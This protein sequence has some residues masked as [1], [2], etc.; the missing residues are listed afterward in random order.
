MQQIAYWSKPD[1]HTSRVYAHLSSLVDDCLVKRHDALQPHIFSLTRDAYRIIKKQP[2]LG[3]RQESWSVLTH[4]C[5]AN[6][7]EILLQKHYPGF[8][9]LPKKE[10]YAMGL[11]PA[12]AEHCGRN[13]D[14]LIYTIIDDYHMQSS[15]LARVQGRAHRPKT[16]FFDLSKTI[17]TWAQIASTFVCAATDSTQYQAHKQFIKTNRLNFSLL[18]LESIW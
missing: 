5:H 12:I 3:S 16:A 7:A 15:R 1:N 14:S 2:P 18:K 13:N 8:K 9:F 4:R 6:S 17:P 11:N 10:L